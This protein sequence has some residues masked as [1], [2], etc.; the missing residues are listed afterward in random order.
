MTSEIPAT[1]ARSFWKKHGVKLL[2]SLVIAGAFAW[3]MRKGGPPL[4]PPA[5]ALAKVNVAS[6][7]LYLLLLIVVHT[8]RATR[9]RFL[10][11]P[12]TDVPVRRILAVSWIGFAAILLMP[13]RAGEF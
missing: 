10:L 12:L 6:C 7:A 4:L 1:P 9:W 11:A 8:T 5:E 13:L 2:V 3:P